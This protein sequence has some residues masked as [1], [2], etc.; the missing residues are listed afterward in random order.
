MDLCGVQ[1]ARQF[2]ERL[3]TGYRRLRMLMAGHKPGLSMGGVATRPTY[4]LTMDRDCHLHRP[5]GVGRVSLVRHD[6]DDTRWRTHQGRGGAAQCAADGKMGA[7][8]P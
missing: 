3:D 2:P 4:Y 7:T 8:T 5:I 1:R 6:V